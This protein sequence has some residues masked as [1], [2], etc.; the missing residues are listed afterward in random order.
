MSVTASSMLAVAMLNSRSK[1]RFVWKNVV[2]LGEGSYFVLFCAALSK[3]VVILGIVSDVVSNAIVP[4]LRLF[5]RQYISVY[6]NL[7]YFLRLIFRS[8]HIC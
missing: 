7:H 3:E 6:C 2:P 1:V 8:Y 4:A 5:S